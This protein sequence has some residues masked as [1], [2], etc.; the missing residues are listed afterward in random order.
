MVV[1]SSARCLVVAGEILADWRLI[2]IDGVASS[3][4]LQSLAIARSVGPG[5]LALDCSAEWP[6][7][8]LCVSAPCWS[9]DLVGV[10]HVKVPMGLVDSNRQAT[11]W[12]H[13][14]RPLP[15][16]SMYR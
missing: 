10:G 5:P 3:S 15:E 8:R 7:E 11:L 16:T 4:D 12:I 1:A 2:G 14:L 13:W 6:R 9:L